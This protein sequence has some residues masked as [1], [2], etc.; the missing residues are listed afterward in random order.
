MCFPLHQSRVNYRDVLM[1]IS[2]KAYYEMQQVIK[3]VVVAEE[4]RKDSVCSTANA[5]ST[6]FLRCCRYH[7][8]EG[9]NDA[10]WTDAS[11]VRACL[12][13]A[14]PPAQR[15][16]VVRDEQKRCLASSAA[17]QPTGLSGYAKQPAA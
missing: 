5:T 15:T 13:R 14:W 3:T 8:T 9:K 6:L 7:N 12:A 1:G 17:S 11:C 10:E 16:G 2:L 4:E